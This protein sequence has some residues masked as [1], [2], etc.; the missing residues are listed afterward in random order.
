MKLSYS[1]TMYSYATM[2]QYKANIKNSVLANNQAWDLVA[3]H[4]LMAGHLTVAGIF[5]NLNWVRHVDLDAPWY[6][7]G[8][9]E[10]AAVDDRI[11][12][13]GGY[14][15][16]SFLLALPRIYVNED[17][18]NKLSVK[19]VYDLVDEG[20]W[21]LDKFFEYSKLGAYD[22]GGDSTWVESAGASD[23]IFGTVFYF[24][25]LLPCFI[26]ASGM[27]ITK[28][29]DTAGKITFDDM[30][31]NKC[32]ELYTRLKNFIHTE[33]SSKLSANTGNSNN[34]F[35]NG[36]AFFMVGEGSSV[37]IFRDAT[38]T[39][40][41][42]VLPKYDANQK[43]YYSQLYES[44]A[45]WAVPIDAPDAQ[46]SGALLETLNYY[47]W[48]NTREAYIEDVLYTKAAT[49]A[50]GARMYDIMINSVVYD[51]CT[52]FQTNMWDTADYHDE[53]PFF[54]FRNGIR[55]Q[56]D[57]KTVWES[58]KGTYAKGTTDLLNRIRSFTA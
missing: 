13:V 55:D 23:D 4:S 14:A 41:A 51:I 16:L 42:V 53:S 40:G 48:L 22:A 20:S 36:Q 19:S 31:S 49:S 38:F 32:Y 25:S 56:K 37:D 28:W 44:V 50:Q 46:R 52:Y 21:T 58:R 57:W 17:I 33:S 2:D 8:L 24:R 11:Y 34:L 43:E 6:P 47:G 3:T 27:T 10:S 45:M 18:M 5:K 1:T 9:T 15:S 54:D 30:D 39:W 29:D 26:Y 12:F 35:K 7:A